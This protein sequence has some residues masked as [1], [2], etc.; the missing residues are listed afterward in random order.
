MGSAI[1]GIGILPKRKKPHAEEGVQLS[2]LLPGFEKALEHRDGPAEPGK[3]PLLPMPGREES[4]PAFSEGSK[5]DESSAAKIRDV[6]GFS[7]RARKMEAMGALASGIAHDF[8]NILTPILLRAE[9]AMA[10]LQEDNPVRNQLEQILS[11]GQRARDLVQQI[12][13][14]SHQNDGERR[15]LQISLVVKEMVKFLRSSLPTSIEIRQDIR[16]AGMVLADLGLIHVLVIELCIRSAHAMRRN[17]GTL[18]VA[19]CDV[20]VDGPE[21]RDLLYL[22]RGAYVKLSVKQTVHGVLP[23][24]E[25]AEQNGMEDAG[26]DIALIRGIVEQHG[27]KMVVYKETGEG[28]T[29]QTFLS[30]MECK[31][32]AGEGKTPLLP[33]GSETVLLVDD[34]PAILET[35]KQMLDYLGYAVVSTTSSVEALEVFRDSPERFDVVITDKTMPRMSGIRLAEKVNR[36]RPDLPILLCSGFDEILQDRELAKVGVR[37]LL[38]KPLTAREI[39]NKI[40]QVL[41]GKPRNP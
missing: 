23:G 17:G 31:A 9:M 36:I 22:P 32:T 14:F 25:G 16:G 35:L 10:Q 7:A 21:D 28:V 15:P 40:R 4:K 12:L 37:A 29:F 20:E 26:P 24:E 39:A 13:N 27:G 2:L 34:E 3:T 33:R 1:K 41:N 11:C 30:R 5:R 8:N 19:L 18:E 38:V 6:G